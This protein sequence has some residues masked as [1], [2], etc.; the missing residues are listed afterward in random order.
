MFH[1]LSHSFF[2]SHD[3]HRFLA[4]GQCRFNI[5]D[6]FFKKRGDPMTQSPPVFDLT[7]EYEWSLLAFFLLVFG[8]T[9]VAEE[10]I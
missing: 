5:W 10:L 3:S 9:E 8:A 1:T 6:T 7:Y 4:L 2:P